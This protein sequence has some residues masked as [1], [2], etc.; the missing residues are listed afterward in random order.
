MQVRAL[1]SSAAAVVRPA[2][3]R[4]AARRARWAHARPLQPRAWKQRAHLCYVRVF[5]AAGSDGR[6]RLF[7]LAYRCRRADLYSSAICALHSGTPEERRQC[8]APTPRPTGNSEAQWRCRKLVLC[9][10][11]RGQWQGRR[12]SSS[13]AWSTP[14]AAAAPAVRPACDELDLNA[15]PM[16]SKRKTPGPCAQQR[17]QAAAPAQLRGCRQ[18]RRL[19]KHCPRRS[20][21]P[22]TPRPPPEPSWGRVAAEVYTRG[23]TSARKHPDLGLCRNSSRPAGH[24]AP[25]CAHSTRTHTR[26]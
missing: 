11:R 8:P 26:R 10:L 9:L 23:H 20:C 21:A 18:G 13:S 3:R 1:R 17:G 4:G 22:H 15:L 12:S 6:E 14:R 19:P 2:G 5:G 16:A 24:G 7:D 25:P